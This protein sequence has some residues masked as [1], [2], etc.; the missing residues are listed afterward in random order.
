MVGTLLVHL[1]LQ[2]FLLYDTLGWEVSMPKQIHGLRGSCLVIPCSFYYRSYPPVN[3]NRI[4]WY[5]YDSS[6]FSYPLVYDPWNPNGVIWKFRWK[7]DLYRNPHSWDCSLLIKTLEQSHHGEKLYTWIDPENVGKSTF[8]FYDVTSTI[9]VDEHPKQPS[10]SVYGGER[11]GDKVTVVCSTYHTCPYRKPTINLYGIEGSDQILDDNF[12]DGQWKTTLTRTGVIK[13]ERTNIQCSVTHYGGR[14]VTAATVKIAKCVHQKIMIEP[15][16]TDVTVGITKNFVCSVYHSCQNENPTITWNYK[17]MQVTREEKKRWGSNQISYS[18]IAFR[19]AKEDH[20]KKLICAAKFSGGDFTASVILHLKRVLLYDAL[21]WEVSMPKDIHGLK[22]SCLVI[23]CSFKYKSNPPKNPRRVVWHQRDSKSSLVCDPSHPDNVNEKFRG[24]TDL[25]GESDWDCSLLIKNLEWSHNGQKLYTRIDPE[26]I[27]WQN[28]ETDDA[29]TTV[30]VE[31]TAQKPSISVYGGERTGDKVTVACSTF[32]TCPYSKPSITLNGIEGSDEI[33]DES[34]KD[35]L[36]K[37][38]LTRTGVVKAESTTIDCLVTHHGGITV[39]ATEV[40]SSKCVHHNIS[41][42]PELADVT[43]GVAQNFTCTIYHSCQNENPTITWNYENMQ[44][45][46]WNKKHTD[47]DQFQIAFSNIT[48][49][50]AKEDHGKRLI[51]TATFSGGNIETY[52]VL[53]VQEYQK[54]VDQFLNETYFQYVADVIPKITAL[55]RSCVVI[56]CSFKT[57]EE[58]STEF[59][60]LWVTRKGGYMFHTDPVD[61]SD[62]FKGRTRLLGNPVEQNCTVE[63]DNVQ[64]HDNGPFCFKAERENERYSFNNSCVFIIMRAPDKPVMSS[65]PENI[66][67][68]TRVAVKCSVNHTCSSHPPEI[69]WSVPTA[70]ETISHNHMG[71]GVWETVSAVTFIPTGYEEED[72]IVCTAKFWGG[73]TQEN[74]AFLSIRR[75]QRLKLEDVGLYAIVPLLV[76]ILI[77]VLAGVIICRRWHRKPRHDMQGSHTHSEQR[78]SFW[79]RFSSR[80]SMPEGRVAWSNR[81]NRSDIGYTGNAPERPPK[82]GQRRS[83]WSRFSRHAPERPPKPEQRQSIWSRFSRHQSPRTNVNLRAEYKANNTCIVSGNKPF[84]KPHMPSPKSEPKSYRGYDSN[85]DFIY[86]NA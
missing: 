25:Y 40:K 66:E 65:L 48:F 21:G 11:M 56:P 23:P 47:L 18:N 28:Y 24:K 83:I 55:P 41:I 19:A 59:R 67:P 10:L 32:H 57:D 76:F 12:K 49:L 80:F 43:E 44:V 84:S 52:V 64:T 68:G 17:N 1:L 29:T 73:K 20:G 78:R 37:I 15:E 35:G 26:N 31:A 6:P 4:V 50:G 2:G 13:A 53:R 79:N 71:G 14:E 8:V 82:A 58:Y 72:E 62:N 22:G 81:G 86:G 70:Q 77:C 54:P 3:P 9:F 85:A 60:V 27:A 51:C 38:T 36:L 46:E 69:T 42:E 16:L 5:Q 75:L 33:K 63:M 30:L 39:T 61:V 34:V 7:T 45:T 74:T